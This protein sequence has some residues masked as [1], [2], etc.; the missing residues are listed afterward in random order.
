MRIARVGVE[1]DEMRKIVHKIINLAHKVI[2][3]ITDKLY[4]VAAEHLVIGENN[5][6]IQGNGDE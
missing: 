4:P 3:I 2:G 1:I 6:E 5:P